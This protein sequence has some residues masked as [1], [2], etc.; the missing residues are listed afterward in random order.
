MVRK[1]AS[2]NEWLQYYERADRVRAIV[3]DPFLRCLRRQIVRDRLFV[4]GFTLCAVVVAS[5]LTVLAIG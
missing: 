3:G 5:A 1:R 2:D 4:V